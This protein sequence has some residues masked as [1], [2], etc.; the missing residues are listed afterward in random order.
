MGSSTDSVANAVSGQMADFGG[1]ARVVAPDQNTVLAPTRSI[2]DCEFDCVGVVP[3]PEVLCS[4]WPHKFERCSLQV[5]HF[6]LTGQEH[7][8]IVASDGDTVLLL[9]ATSSL[10]TRPAPPEVCGSLCQA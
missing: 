7:L 3:T 5:T 2:G 4:G 8:I 9:V 10:L 6:Q 1:F